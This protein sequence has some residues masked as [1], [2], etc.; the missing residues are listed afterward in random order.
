VETVVV[1][2]VVKKDT[3]WYDISLEDGRTV[4]TKARKLADAAFQSKGQEVEVELNTQKKGSFTNIYLNR[5]GDVADSKASANGG[6]ARR[7][8]ASP[9]REEAPREVVPV[10]N[11]DERIARQWAFGR[12]VEMYITLGSSAFPPTDADLDEIQ[13]AAEGLLE[14]ARP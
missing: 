12:A 5:I 1:D 6:G 10:D 4:S 3:G 7:K 8:A 11:R 2:D 14:R 9:K 13:A